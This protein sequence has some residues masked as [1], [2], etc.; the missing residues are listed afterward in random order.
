[1]KDKPH[2]TDT[3]QERGFTVI[4]LAVA[5]GTLGLIVLIISL[6]LSRFTDIPREQLEQALITESARTLLERI[7]D[8]IR[9][10]QDMDTNN[11]NEI[12]TPPDLGWLNVQN[13]YEIAFFGDGDYNGHE[14]R[15]RYF[16]EGTTLKRGIVRL[17]AKRLPPN[18]RTR[19][20]ITI[21]NNHVRNREKNTPLF[22]Y[23]T[24]SDGVVVTVRIT[25][26]IDADQNQFPSAATVE[27]KVTP[28][29]SQQFLR[30]RT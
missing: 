25:L 9:S 18:W 6:A 15:V 1:M 8:T 17:S 16:L 4:E 2:H 24:D 30:V 5:L 26:I 19:E 12:T 23:I 13:D 3:N 11:D 21:M 27:T 22:T 14:D 29:G 7:S 10:A 20:V 28:R